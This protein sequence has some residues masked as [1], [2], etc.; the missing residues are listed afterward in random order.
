MNID[1]LA[2]DRDTVKGTTDS[3]KGAKVNNANQALEPI[4]LQ[5]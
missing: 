4:L 3:P 5:L 1:Q 2:V